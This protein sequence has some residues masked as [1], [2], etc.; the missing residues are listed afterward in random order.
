MKSVKSLARIWI[1]LLSCLCLSFSSCARSSSLNDAEIDAY[2]R[3]KRHYLQGDYE[4]AIGVIE[5]ERFTYERGHQALLLK[6]KAEFLLGRSELAE[7]ILLRL[8]KIHP[9]YPEATLWLA[10]TLLAEGKIDEA[11]STVIRAM[12]WDPDDPRLLAIMAD[13]QELKKDYPKAFEYRLRAVDFADETGKEELELAELYW[14]FAQN[15]KALERIA[16]AR[17]MISGKSALAKPLA[18][19]AARLSKGNQK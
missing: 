7:P 9:G 4:R 8:V 2:A 18:E 17:A 3:A 10:R 5:E 1:V 6:A 16:R 11:E 14:R 19:L 15:D 13:V 12:R